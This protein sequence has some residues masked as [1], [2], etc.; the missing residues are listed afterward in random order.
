MGPVHL[1]RFLHKILV[2]DR[3]MK[4]NCANM[5]QWRYA[6]GPAD[7]EN[8]AHARAEG[9]DGM[10][11]CPQADW[12]KSLFQARCDRAIDFRLVT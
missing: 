9:A 3:L 4:M 2:F 11:H 8:R 7:R 1:A 6:Q 10:R 5:Y 12:F